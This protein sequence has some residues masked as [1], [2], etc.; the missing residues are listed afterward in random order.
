MARIAAGE[1]LLMAH[2]TRII[3]TA[4][5][6]L[7]V[8]LA[9]VTPVLLS[10]LFGPQFRDAVP[11]AMILF[12]AQVPLAGA[13]VLS[14]A[15]QADGAPLIPTAGEVIALVITVVGLALLLRPFGGV[16]AAIV[17]LAAYGMSF[18]F[19]IVMAHRRL[20]VPMRE[21]LVLSRADVRWACQLLRPSTLKPTAA[22]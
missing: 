9:L 16:G 7:N 17:S 15:L 10:V 8:A 21:F 13:T 3:V 20:R 18:L 14:A 19:Q 6:A 1:P 22:A 12:I 4:T 11:M 2:A 5:V